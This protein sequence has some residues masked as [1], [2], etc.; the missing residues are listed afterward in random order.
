MKSVIKTLEN[1][2]HELKIELRIWN[3]PVNFSER[4]ISECNQEIKEHEQAI[5]LLTL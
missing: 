2:I 3:D 4:I 5:I 1:K